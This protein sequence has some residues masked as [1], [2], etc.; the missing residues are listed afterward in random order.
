MPTKSATNKG[1]EA[2]ETE[3]S[4]ATPRAKA[5]LW[6][7]MIVD[8]Q[9]ILRVGLR[10]TLSAERGLEIVAEASGA[11]DAVKA[12]RE[13]KPDLAIVDISLERG[14]GL[15]L[16]K[17]LRSDF[18]NL[19]LIVFSSQDEEL[20]AERALRAGA[21]GYIAKS[22][23][24]DRLIEAIRQILSGATAL[25]PEM[26]ERLVQQALGGNGE[27][28]GVESL[29]DRELEVFQLI[30]GGLSTRKIAKQLCISVKTVETHR[31]NIK[32]KLNAASFSVQRTRCMSEADAP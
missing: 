19:K 15:D 3:P 29:S 24:A 9:P 17:Q 13:H 20:Y 23:S 16:L 1:A 31:E 7:L 6:R 25:S 2:N 22:E 14:S 5:K 18:P 8:E 11:P 27:P 10:E 12:A 26:T 30:G 28:T 4:A 32:R 21:D